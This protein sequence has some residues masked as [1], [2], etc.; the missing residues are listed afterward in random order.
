M[1]TRR[2]RSIG[3][4][5]LASAGDVA[6]FSLRTVGAVR[7]TLTHYRTEVLD[8][9]AAARMA[10][11]HVTALQLI[12]ADPDAQHARQTLLSAEEQRFQV[13]GLAGP[14]RVLPPHRAHEIFE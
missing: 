2:W 3:T 1:A 13:E 9:S 6:T 11:Y 5:T 4:E 7:Y 10:G 14:C 12:A 8:A